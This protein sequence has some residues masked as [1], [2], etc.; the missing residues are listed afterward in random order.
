MKELEF[1]HYGSDRFDPLCF[2]KIQN[3]ELSVIN[4]PHGGLWASPVTSK[5]GWID[6]CKSEGYF[7]K[8]DQTKSFTFKLRE[9]AKVLIIDSKTDISNIPTLSVGFDWAMSENIDFEQL[10]KQYDAIFLT[11][12]ALSLDICSCFTPKQ[13]NF[14]GWDCESLLVLNQ[15][16][17]LFD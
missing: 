14:Y 6:W 8:D 4:K 9:D 3:R 7:I 5:F 1:I 2:T 16:C 10:S 12:E 13:I 11:E 17:I 15:S